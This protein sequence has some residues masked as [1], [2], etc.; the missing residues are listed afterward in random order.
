M[1]SINKRL[2]NLNRFKQYYET[3]FNNCDFLG[4][5]VNWAGLG[6]DFSIFT[7]SEIQKNRSYGNLRFFIL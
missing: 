7:S 4:I 1:D 6:Y 3:F 2:I 5:K